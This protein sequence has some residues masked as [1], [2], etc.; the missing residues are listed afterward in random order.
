MIA[1]SLGIVAVCVLPLLPSLPQMI[2]LLTLMVILLIYSKISPASSSLRGLI[3][4]IISAF[5]AGVLWAAGYG[6]LVLERQIPS[7]WEGLDLWVQG[8]IVGLPESE[9][10]STDKDSE[11]SVRN[12][13]IQSFDFEIDKEVCNS[14]DSHI[15]RCFSALKLIRLKWYEKTIVKPGQQW[16]FLVR[17]KKPM[18]A[19]NPGTFDYQTWLIAQGFGANGYV[20]K[21]RE[22]RLLGETTNSIDS[23]RSRAALMFDQ[24]LHGLQ[25]IGIFKALILGDKRGIESQQWQLFSRTGTTHLMVISGLHVGLLASLAF[26]LARTGILLISRR[27]SADRWGALFAVFVALSYAAAAGLSLPTQRALIMISVW[28]AVVFFRRQVAPVSGLLTALLVCL[29]YDPL[30][31]VGSSFWMS[32]MA[33]SCIFFAVTG[34]KSSSAGFLKNSLLKSL[35][36]QYWV[37]IGLLPVLA[38]LMGQLSLVSPFANVLLVPLFAVVIVPFTILGAIILLV[39]VLF[40]ATAETIQSWLGFWHCL[41]QLMSFAFKC[42]TWLDDNNKYGLRYIPGLPWQLK[43][44]AV[45]GAVVLLLPRG[46]PLRLTG[47]ALLA[48]LFTYRPELLPEG[49]IRLT[50]LDVGQGLSIVVQT[51]NHRLIYDTGP[52][53]GDR[54][55]AAKSNVVP[56][57]R[58]WGID[59][60]DTLVL[61]HGDNDHAGGRG[62]LIENIPIEQLYYGEDIQGLPFQSRHCDADINWS[63]DTVKFEFLGSGDTGVTGDKRASKKQNPNDLSCVMMITAGETKF[64]FTGDIGKKVEKELVSNRGIDLFATVLIA[65]HHGSSNS[66]SQVFVERVNAKHVVFSSGYR[67][68]FKHPRSDVVIRYKSRHAIIHSTA[69]DGAITFSV[70][71]G[72]LKTVSHYRDTIRRY[73]L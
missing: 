60:V 20:R 1:G 45:F 70:H 2:F 26:I 22:N 10:E 9:S 56:Y 53:M 24:H 68:Q 16:R 42:L 28:M 15:A 52:A 13:D 65:P 57:L 59:S 47:V 62:E 25:N 7:S 69:T 35:S 27:L 19:A 37:F 44:V 12:R 6:Y 33:V 67:N 31:P 32:F 49:D 46:M 21:H 40:G 38:I 30:A 4:P 51:Q 43:L 5:L 55:S 61:S 18:G 41:D 58:Y 11:P 71:E 50:V 73:W 8:T 66:S 34:R 17:L 3:T 23:L 48:P 29:L 63:W 39:S 14:L 54:F 64:L 36:S 72:K